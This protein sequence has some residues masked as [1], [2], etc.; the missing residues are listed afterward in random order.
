MSLDIS[1]LK[2][3]RH[4]GRKTI[5]QCP[6]C[7]EAEHDHKG[8]HLIINEDGRFGCVLY[9]G[10]SADARAHRKRIFE[11]CGNKEIQPL[12]VHK[13]ST[14]NTPGYPK[15]IPSVPSGTRSGTLG[16]LGRVLQ[17]HALQ[18]SEKNG[19]TDTRLATRCK[20]GKGV[21]GVLKE[22]PHRPLGEHER[23][24]ML[25][26]CDRDIDSLILEARQLFNATVVA[27]DP[28]AG[29]NRNPNRHSLERQLTLGFNHMTL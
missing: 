12:I 28:P 16:R 29:A 17:T 13:P 4:R 11:F 26:W 7:A 20:S 5:A 25:R 6:A 10:H 3:V 14:L 21:L 27:I 8:E 1:K 19:S 22:P 15:G 23:D 2:H 18:S 9:P 24:L